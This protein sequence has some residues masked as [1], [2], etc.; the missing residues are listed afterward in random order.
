MIKEV[1]DINEMRKALACHV[2]N[3]HALAGVRT[4]EVRFLLRPTCKPSEF[5]LSAEI[6]LK[7]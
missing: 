7:E 5:E 2:A 3:M 1:L 4:F 6:S